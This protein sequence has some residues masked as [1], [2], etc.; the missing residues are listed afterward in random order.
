MS[1][2][3]ET[4]IAAALASPLRAADLALL[5]D[6]VS[7]TAASATVQHEDLQR[8]ALDP[9]SGVQAAEAARQEAERVGFSL[10]RLHSAADRLGAL[11]R[12]AMA[13]EREAAEARAAAAL[14]AKQDAARAQWDREYPLLANR[15]AGLVRMV[16]D[17]GLSPPH[18]VLHERHEGV[19][20]T[21]RVY[22]PPPSRPEFRPDDYAPS[23]EGDLVI[24]AIGER[25]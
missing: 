6:E 18:I 5:I 25:K 9:G 17:A 24:K 23:C 7:A 15:I 11:H 12:A 3:L 8:A 20:P 14:K 2:P 13:A 22:L 1:Q 10:Q 19:S 4:R 16:S 21:F